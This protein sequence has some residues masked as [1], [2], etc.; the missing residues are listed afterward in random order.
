MGMS[1]AIDRRP[2]WSEVDPWVRVVLVFALTT[3]GRTPLDQGPAESTL[4][5]R[6]TGGGNSS[7]NG[8][9]RGGSGS[10]GTA[11]FRTIGNGG[12]DVTRGTGGTG[13]GSS[14]SN[15]TGR[16]GIGSGGTSSFSTGGNPGTYAEGGDAAVAGTPGVAV[17]PFVVGIGRPE[18][19]G[20]PIDPS[21]PECGPTADVGALVCRS[22]DCT[23]ASVKAHHCGIFNWPDGTEWVFVCDPF[24]GCNSTVTVGAITEYSDRITIEYTVKPTCTECATVT[25]TCVW[26][27][28][29]LSSK[30]V[31]A[32]GTLEPQSC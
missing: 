21:L 12:T 22:F 6:G 31:I 19:F 13:G 3:C 17:T 23:E 9:G 5:S 24:G 8:T 14:S 29:G 30:P 1:P 20:C 7:S 25:R 18:P 10:G 32:S 11:S 16:G 27:L 28:L 4:P 15:G 2:A 26:L